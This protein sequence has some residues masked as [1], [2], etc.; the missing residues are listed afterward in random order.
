MKIGL[1]LFV[2]MLAFI[3]WPE[4]SVAQQ[5]RK[6]QSIPKVSPEVWKKVQQIGTVRVIASLNVPGR[7][8]T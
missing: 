4:A 7:T 5:V 3:G 6:T 2:A 1:F 8:S